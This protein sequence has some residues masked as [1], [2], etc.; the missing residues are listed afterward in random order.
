MYFSKQ[1]FYFNNT[2]IEYF[3]SF[4]SDEDDDGLESFKHPGVICSVGAFGVGNI[5]LPGITGILIGNYLKEDSI[6]VNNIK[7]FMFGSLGGF[8]VALLS[9]VLIGY[10]Y[11]HLWDEKTSF[12][13]DLFRF[14]NFSALSMQKY[15]CNIDQYF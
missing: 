4:R 8:G 7:N 13:E 6:E 1:I 10:D 12:S 3:S 9:P 5:L 2:N 15:I 14:L 11:N